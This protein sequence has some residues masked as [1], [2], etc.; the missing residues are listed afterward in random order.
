MEKKAGD[1]KHALERDWEQTKHDV[2]R[3]HGEDLD[4]NI[5]DTLKQAAGKAPIPPKGTPNRK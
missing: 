5:G 1:V 3:K 2:S 4:Q